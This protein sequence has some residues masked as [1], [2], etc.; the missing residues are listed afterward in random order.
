MNHMKLSL[1]IVGLAAG[2]WLGFHVAHSMHE[3]AEA[4][5]ARLAAMTDCEK[6]EVLLATSTRAPAPPLVI[7][8]GNIRLLE[9]IC[10]STANS[11]APN[12]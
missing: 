11:P 3:N 5:A 12:Y 10:K 9:T 6:R 2:L 8:N 4:P 7:S 1:V